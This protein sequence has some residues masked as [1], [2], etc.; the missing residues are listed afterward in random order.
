[1]IKFNKENFHKVKNSFLSGF[2]AIALASLT[3]TSP[4]LAEKNTITIGI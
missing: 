2:L 3:I 1:M 4:A